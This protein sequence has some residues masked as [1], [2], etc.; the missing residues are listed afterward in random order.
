MSYSMWVT[1]FFSCRDI[2]NIKTHKSVYTTFRQ[3]QGNNARKVNCGC[4]YD[5]YLAYI[6]K[7][8]LSGRNLL[9]R[10]DASVFV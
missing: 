9:S 4:V 6:L 2:V 10:I 1:L 3:T 5:V 8:V 7:P